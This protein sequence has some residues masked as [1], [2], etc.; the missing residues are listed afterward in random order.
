MRGQVP[1]SHVSAPSCSRHLLLSQPAAAEGPCLSGLRVAP[2]SHPELSPYALPALN[3]HT[4][5][6]QQGLV[7]SIPLALN[8]VAV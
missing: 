6:F 8:T 4:C 2:Q 7:L 5:S 3:S 1:R